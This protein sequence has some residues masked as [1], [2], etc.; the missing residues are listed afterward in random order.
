[1]IHLFRRESV[2]AADCAV[3]SPQA[4]RSEAAP[5]PRCPLR[6]CCRPLAGEPGLS[7]FPNDGKVSMFGFPSSLMH[8]SK[9]HIVESSS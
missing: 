7:G 5:M 9:V 1:V 8:K 2:A 4:L 3:V 6:G